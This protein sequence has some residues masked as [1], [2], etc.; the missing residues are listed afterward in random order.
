MAL[1]SQDLLDVPDAIAQALSLANELRTRLETNMSSGRG[2]DSKHA[3][4]LTALSGTLKALS[5]EA[6]LWANTI[7]EI[8]KNATPEQRTAASVAHLTSLPVGA[9]AAAYRALCE[10]EAHTPQRLALT[11]AE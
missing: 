7:N 6:R 3:T 8:G 1:A 11:L 10:H 4:A 5:T 9:R 2:Y